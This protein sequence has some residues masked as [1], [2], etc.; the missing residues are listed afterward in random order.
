MVQKYY[1]ISSIHCTFNY[2]D[3]NAEKKLIQKRKLV[4]EL[5]FE[6]CWS[7]NRIMKALGVSKHFVIRWTQDPNQDVTVDRRGW[8]SGQRRKWDSDTEDRIIELYQLLKSDPSEFFHG[9]TAIAQQWRKLY[10]DDQVPPLRTIGQIMKDLGL[11]TTNKTRRKKG[12]ARYLCYPEKTV[13]EGSIGNRVIEADFIRRYLKGRSAPVHFIGFSAKKTPRLRYFERV[14]A[15]TVDTFINSCERFFEHFE[16]PDVLKVDNAAT[17]IGSLS[18]KRSLSKTILYLLG[19]QVCPVFSVPR[20]PFSQASIEGNNSVFARHFWNRRLFESIEDVDRQL[21]W[22]NDSSLRY[23]DYQRPKHFKERKDFIPC[24]YFLRQVRENSTN[25]GQGYI[26]VLNE[27][28]VLPSPYINYF[29]FSVWNLLTETLTVSIEQGG[30]LKKLK[31]QKFLI[32][33]RTKQNLKKGGARSF[34]T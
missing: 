6:H 16:V 31:E 30:S 18:G 25:P 9:A 20:R 12:A 14:E 22:F 17:F 10:P 7:K 1:L 13:Y 23:T 3:C 21:Q 11:S 26:D 34:C 24:L 4:N 5:Y 33:E 15:L 2:Q 32:N 19:K 27:E 29:V 28:V 8:L